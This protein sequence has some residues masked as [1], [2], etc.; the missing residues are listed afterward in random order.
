MDDRTI[1]FALHEMEGIGW[2]SISRLVS[3]PIPLSEWM[4]ASIE[5]LERIGIVTSKA[6]L[7]RQMLS[8]SY[9]ENRLAL[10]AKEGIDYITRLDPAYPQLLAETGRPPW[11]LYYRGHLDMLNKPLI[12][13]VGTRVPTAY[14]IRAAEKLADQLSQVGW[15]VVSGMAKGIDSVSHEAALRSSGSTIAV[16]GTAINVVYPPENRSLHAEIVEKG[17]ILSEYPIG[18]KSHPGLFPQRNRVIAGLSL[19]VLVV[20][21]AERSGSLITADHALE[22]SRDVFAV[23]G[24]ISSPKSEGANRLI[25]QGAKLVSSAQD[26]LEEYRHMIAVEPVSARLDAPS[27]SKLTEP[28]RL[29][30]RI[31]SHEPTTIDQLLEKSKYTFGHLHSVLLSLLMKKLIEQLPGSAYII[32]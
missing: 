13:M 10:Y 29:V 14:G 8:E 6:V 5:D 30:Y 4:N 18:T 28:E 7:I 21:A 27:P 3:Q 17:L 16:L 2:N 22:A 9:I 1:L 24:P 23:P 31:L 12:G 15:G 19:G 32:R 20:E 25:K 26:I 11:V